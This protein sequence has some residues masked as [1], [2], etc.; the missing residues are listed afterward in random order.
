MPSL[1]ITTR[2]PLCPSCAATLTHDPPTSRSRI[3]HPRQAIVATGQLEGTA[4]KSEPRHQQL[5]RKAAQVEVLVGLLKI[6]SQTN[7]GS[8]LTFWRDRAEQAIAQAEAMLADDA[9]EH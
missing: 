1:I 3:D 6:L 2:L 9:P 4:D 5:E 7:G 8:D